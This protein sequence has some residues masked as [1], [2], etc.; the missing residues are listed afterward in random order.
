MKIYIWH[1]TKEKRELLRKEKKYILDEVWSRR[2]I[3]LS[4]HWKGN[5]EWT[6]QKHWARKDTWRRHPETL[7]TQR[8][9]TKT[10]RNTG[11]TKTHDED[12]QKHQCFWM[13]SSCVFVCPVFLDCPFAITLSVI[14]KVYISPTSHLV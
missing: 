9:M 4:D 1:C 12:I 2:Y 3:N 14:T 8:H 5:R 11:H 13:S 6:I 7:G 10:S